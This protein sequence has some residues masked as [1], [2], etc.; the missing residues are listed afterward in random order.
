MTKPKKDFWE[1]RT[2]PMAEEEVKEIALSILQGGRWHFIKSEHL[3]EQL[4][5]LSFVDLS[6]YRKRDLEQLGAILGNARY[7]ASR[8]VNGLNCYM[9][10]RFIHKEDWSRIVEKLI[11]LEQA[12]KAV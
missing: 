1:D 3:R 12:I 8:S 9:G 5:F 11:A 10:G 7:I 2:G 6:E 4:L